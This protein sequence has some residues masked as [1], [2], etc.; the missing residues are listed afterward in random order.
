MGGGKVNR[1]PNWGPA[2]IRQLLSRSPWKG[3]LPSE[4]TFKRV[5]DKAGL[6]RHRRRRKAREQGRRLQNRVKV[7]RPNRLWTID[8]KGWWYTRDRKR[9]EPLT[10]R[11]DSSRYILRAQA[12]ANS[13]AETVRQ[14]FARVFSKHGLPEIIRSD[15]GSPFAAC[16][17]PL[18]LTR[19]S[20]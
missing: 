15:N 6:V 12:T 3:E 2:K 14:Q 5:L 11:D 10:I 13:R 8:F 19:L 17:S 7:E 18:G 9:F 20:A 4:S 16:N 1:R